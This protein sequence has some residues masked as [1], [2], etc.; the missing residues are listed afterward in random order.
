LGFTTSEP[1]ANGQ[2]K[3][4]EKVVEGNHYGAIS[5]ARRGREA[6]GTFQVGSGIRGF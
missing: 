5:E 6:E 1:K 4:Y 2:L 3:V